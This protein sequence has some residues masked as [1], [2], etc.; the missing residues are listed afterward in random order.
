MRLQQ[1]ERQGKRIWLDYDDIDGDSL[2][3]CLVGCFMGKNLG[4]GG[5]VAIAR[6]WGTLYK[7]H[8]HKSGWTIFRFDMAIDR[9]TVLSAAPYFTYDSPLFLKVMPTYFLFDKD[10]KFAPAWVQIYRLPP[11]CWTERVLSLVGSEIRRPLYTNKLT[12][13]R[14]H[15]RYARLLIENNMDGDQVDTVPIT[16]LTGA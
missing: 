7:F 12:H 5:I 3:F 1:Y 11:D 15:I 16:L 10:S 2:G 14:E 9:D 4:R 8:L 13:T 6:R